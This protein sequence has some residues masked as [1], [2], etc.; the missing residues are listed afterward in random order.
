MREQSFPGKEQIGMGRTNRLAQN[1]KRVVRAARWSVVKCA[2]RLASKRSARPGAPTS[3]ADS[4]KTLS[5]I[6]AP[7]YRWITA[8][9]PRELFRRTDYC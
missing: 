9:D 6:C 5:E 4:P 1:S 3:G 8:S 7:S 2:P